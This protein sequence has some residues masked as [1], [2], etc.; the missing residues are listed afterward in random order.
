[1]YESE[2]ERGGVLRVRQ[3]NRQTNAARER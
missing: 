3:K 2:T 1:V